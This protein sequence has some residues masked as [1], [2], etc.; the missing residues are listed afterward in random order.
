M[1]KWSFSVSA[2]PV[3]DS[4][5]LRDGG[6]HDLKGAGFIQW[7]RQLKKVLHYSEIEIIGWKGIQEGKHETYSTNIYSG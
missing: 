5:C 1:L 6:K 7:G 2:K 4:G 3:A